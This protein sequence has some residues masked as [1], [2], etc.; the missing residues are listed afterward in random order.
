MLPSNSRYFSQKTDELP[1][2]LNV[3]WSESTEHSYKNTWTNLY[4]NFASLAR[5]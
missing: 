3:A 2:G 1:N 5:Q 4:W